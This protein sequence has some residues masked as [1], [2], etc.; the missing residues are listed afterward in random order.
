MGTSR[1]PTPSQRN[2][3]SIQSQGTQK[4]KQAKAYQKER[5]QRC[6][7]DPTMTQYSRINHT[8]DH[9]RNRHSVGHATCGPLWCCRFTPATNESISAISAGDNPRRQAK[10]TR[11]IQEGS[12]ATQ[13]TV[14][15]FAGDRPIKPILVI[16]NVATTIDYEPDDIQALGSRAESSD[17]ESKRRQ[18]AELKT[19]QVEQEVREVAQEE[20]AEC[21]PLCGRVGMVGPNPWSSLVQLAPLLRKAHLRFARQGLEP[22]YM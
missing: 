20:L 14:V 21:R 22:C 15:G 17:V 2:H 5:Q 6:S 18:E 13:P 12:E 8:N 3:P 1:E 19:T 7:A 10:R 9:L 16:T 4:I 11:S